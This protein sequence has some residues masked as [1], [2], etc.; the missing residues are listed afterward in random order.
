MRQTIG[1][2]SGK[3]LLDLGCHDGR[4][5][6]LVRE[7][8]VL[9]IS[10]DIDK[11]EFIGDLIASC[12]AIPFPDDTFDVVT[13]ISVDDLLAQEHFYQALSEVNRVLKPN[14]HFVKVAGNP[15]EEAPKH[16]EWMSKYGV[17]I[18]QVK[19]GVQQ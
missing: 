11:H 9:P 17:C 3:R 16:W 18:F 5:A 15:M 19:K 7:E 2:L 4:W 1:D 13:M 6:K 8:G 10:L 14:G 12:T